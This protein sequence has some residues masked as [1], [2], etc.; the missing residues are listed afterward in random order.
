MMR[1]DTVDRLIDALVV[2]LVRLH[3][4]GFFW[5][6]CSLSNTLFRR[7][8]GAFAAYLV[9]AETGELQPKLSSGQR[10]HD[11]ANAEINIAGELMD[12]QAGRLLDDSVDAIATAE[13]VVERYDSLWTELTSWEAFD[14]NDRWRIDEF[15]VDLSDEDAASPGASSASTTSAS[16]S[17]SWTLLP[18][19]VAAPCV[20]SPRSSTLDTTPGDSYG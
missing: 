3:L 18:T 4:V 16:T 20:C 15:K 1:R 2:L 7:D 5:G 12:L 17:R 11:L 19:S 10:S 6:D 8:A 9:D 13:K 14:V